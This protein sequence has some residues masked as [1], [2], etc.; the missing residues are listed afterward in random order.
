M[1]QWSW[2]NY[3]AKIMTMAFVGTHI[4]LIALIAF[5]TTRTATD[6][7]DVLSTVGVALVAT[8]VGTG[9]TLFVLNHLLRPLLL[10][11]RV[12][13]AYRERRELT[14]L[15]THYTDEVGTLMSDASRTLHE[16]DASLQSVSFIDQ[17]TGL[18]NRDRFLQKVRDRTDSGSPLAV[19]A[20]HV[21]NYAELA[22]TLD[23]AEADRFVRTLSERLI[24]QLGHSHELARVAADVFAFYA[25][26]DVAQATTLL[27]HLRDASSSAISIAGMDIQP[28]IRAGVALFPEDAGAADIL[29]ETPSRPLPLPRPRRRSYS[30]P[31]RLARQHGS[32]SSSNKNCARR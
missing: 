27:S 1:S 13:R 28:V 2:L 30:M 26:A 10:T 29:L 11:S 12:L 19:C 6:W 25:K 18:A 17:T 32:A 21:G 7:Q 16:L 15:P 4:P 5:Y 22:T 31:P 14:T 24:G 23:Q 8:L 20:L 9:I 3:R